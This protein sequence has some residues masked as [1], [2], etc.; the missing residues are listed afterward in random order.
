MSAPRIALVH[1]MP[2][3]IEP[4]AHVFHETWPQARVTHLLDDSLP[5]DL[6]AAGGIT[7]AMLER[8]IAMARYCVS[9]GADAVL[10]TCSAFGTA[11]DAA[12]QAVAVPVLKP[13]EAMLEEA[14]AAGSDL[15][16]LATFEPSIPSLKKEFEDLAAARGIKL[17]LKT[18]TV[19]AAIAA[20]QTGRTAEHDRLIAA[21]AAEMGVCDAL[22]LGQ[23]S[24]ARA[25]T[26]IPAQPG[27]KVVTSPHSAVARLKQIFAQR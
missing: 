10:F 23:F 8:F 6:T 12:K 21:A 26:G 7:D 14:L 5:A 18:R 4:V 9:C 20:L 16:L 15:A 19:P 2:V 11:I 25:A 24:M 27:R 3:A 17:K 22:V 13:N 1:A